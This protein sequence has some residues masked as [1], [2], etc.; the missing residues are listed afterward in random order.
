[1]AKN[2]RQQT[3]G[4][5][6]DDPPQS[7]P[8]RDTREDTKA[9][10]L[11]GK[12]VYVVDSHA[13]IYQVFHAMPN[14]TSPTGQPVGAIHGFMRDIVDILEKR[15]P[16]Y[17][18]CAFDFS[19]RTFR[20]DFYPKYK[21]TRESMPDDL[22]PQIGN[23]QRM[24]EA[25]GVAILTLEN[26]EADDIL[27]TVARRVEDGGGTCYLVTNDKDCR[28]L[29]T[30]H[31]F[32][33]NIRKNAVLDTQALLEDWGIRPNQ[34]VDFQALVGDSVDCVPGIP[35]IGPKIA[36][37]L[38][39]KYD[40]LDNVLDHASE[41]TG[42]KR[43]ENLMNGR[44]AALLSRRLV[45]LD[46]QVPIDVD[47]SAGRVGG[48]NVPAVQELCQEFGFRQ[49]AERLT[50]LTPQPKSKAWQTRYETIATPEK[51]DWLVAEL[52]RQSRFACD[53]E[54]TN[55]NPRWAEIVGYSFCWEAGEAYYV[56]VLAPQG[57]PRLDPQ[58]T[59]AALRPVLEN[60][61][62][63]K[64]GQNIKYD[65]I[66]LRGAGTD[67]RGPLFDTMVADYLLEAG[68]RNHGIDELALRYLDHTTIKISSLIGKGKH[69][70]RM[71]EVPVKTITEYAAEDAD[72]PF[73]LTPL[74]EK[75]LAD[76]NLTTL[77]E[78]VE[79]PLVEVLAEMEFNGIRVDVE[80]LTRLSEQYGERIAQLEL[81]VFEIAGRQF[82]IN[83][84]S[85]LS[86]LLFDEFELPR[87]KKNSTDAE[88]LEQL[89]ALHPL[90]AKVIEYRQQAKL[91][92]T[93]V[94]A[95]PKLVHPETGRVHTSFKQDVAATGRLSSTDPNLQNIPVRT[96]AGREIRAAFVPGHDGWQLLT[97][98]YSQIELRVLAHFCGD[99]ALRQAFAEDQDIHTSV[100]AEVYGVELDEVTPQ[101]RRSAKAINF[102]I[103]YGQSPFGLAKSLN[104]GKEDAAAFI[105]AYFDR[106][107]LVDE[108]MMK[109]L[110]ECRQK[111]YVSTIL[112][113]RRAVQGIRDS[114]QRT[115]SRQ[116][117]LPERIAI[118]TV[119]QGS[120]A[121]LIKLAM[122]NIH[123]RLQ[124]ERP[125][126]R[127][128]LQIHDELIF[129]GP[130]EEGTYLSELVRREMAAAG[131][132]SVPL[133]VDV[134]VGENWAAGEAM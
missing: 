110:E 66:V 116:R 121:D 85:Q 92:N 104:I 18:F 98:D 90:P 80:R 54:T 33:F 111:G 29:I 131:T 35:L 117:N 73:R 15:Q 23:I 60:P 70:I 45:Q 42:K 49:L 78:T 77:F 122:I 118:N 115:Q 27:A 24:L 26:Y 109:T 46:D 84:P 71:D 134:K 125:R 113:R 93:Y 6:W 91:K 38:L 68:Q 103:I 3:L 4:F 132:L 108:F 105:D 44:E 13:L 82:N 51:L 36:R 55:V 14:M 21:E 106:Y 2:T 48:L 72:V 62:I 76:D 61:N 37:E 129:E 58:S 20:H 87:V 31:V 53:T 112:G 32:L 75:R 95:L 133:K 120:A 96:E 1:M 97:A 56:P 52:G 100:A 9:D 8:A 65:M 7:A 119:I 102:G 114:S 69:Q 19:A 41:L 39:E 34:V 63:Q 5:G 81:E 130:G 99:L 11:A 79:M 28:Q 64:I 22:R 127:M 43:R 86:T 107:P 25:M 40:N 57:E 88:V 128:L 123:R 10:S 16:D 101:M 17:L 67:L 94:D 83:S 89:A 47:W 126:A 50:G 74:L 59:A 12:T 30:D 124:E